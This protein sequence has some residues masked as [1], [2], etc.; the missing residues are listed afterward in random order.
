M[1]P[2]VACHAQHTHTHTNTQSINKSINQSINQPIDR[3]RTDS[4][5]HTHTESIN[6]SRTDYSPTGE[7]GLALGAPSRTQGAVS[8][9]CGLARLP[10]QDTY[11]AAFAVLRMVAAQDAEWGLRALF[12]TP[13]FLSLMTDGSLALSNLGTQWRFGVMDAV[14][15][16]PNRHVLHAAGVWE[17]VK[18]YV[19]AGP[20][21][22]VAPTPEAAVHNGDGMS[23]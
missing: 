8:Q 16:N 6:H 17:I 10:F 19:K 21:R 12:S 1:H 11:V 20:F 13:E 14:A 5:T 2:V 3:S 7:L 18:R 22:A 4:L 15:R 9:V 23:L